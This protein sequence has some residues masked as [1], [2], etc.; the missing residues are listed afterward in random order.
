MYYKQI[1]WN[2]T[3]SSRVHKGSRPHLA[4]ILADEERLAS[5][6]AQLSSASGSRTP[7]LTFAFP[8][9][10]LPAPVPAALTCSKARDYSTYANDLIRNAY[11][12][13][14]E[15]ANK[16]IGQRSTLVLYLTSSCGKNSRSADDILYCMTYFMTTDICLY[17]MRVC[18]RGCT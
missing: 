12:T 15:I 7:E 2:E 16:I 5:S 9:P 3:A 14:S 10:A 11:T 1:K 18:I 4:L 8:R 17:S 13:Y 6:A